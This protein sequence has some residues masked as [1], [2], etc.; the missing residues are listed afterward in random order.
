MINIYYYTKAEPKVA[1]SKSCPLCDLKQT[2]AALV[3]TG[4][5]YLGYGA[6]V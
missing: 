1:Q 6:A 2:I 4:A 5:T 3:A